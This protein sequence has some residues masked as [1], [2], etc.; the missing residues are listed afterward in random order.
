LRWC[1]E[2]DLSSG[3]GSIICGNTDCKREKELK[4][5][6]VNMNYVEKQEEKSALVT[7]Y[8]CKKC[9]K[10]LSKMYRVIKRM[11]KKNKNKI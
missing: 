9:G 11:E 5:F 6:E 1:N 7:L 2:Y 8:L 3:K 4:P 10:R